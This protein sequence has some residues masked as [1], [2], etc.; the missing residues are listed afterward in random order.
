MHLQTVLNL[1]ISL[2]LY[3]AAKLEELEGQ[4][5]HFLVDIHDILACSN[6]NVNLNVVQI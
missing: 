1:H 5:D 3:I 6:L 4:R 2:T